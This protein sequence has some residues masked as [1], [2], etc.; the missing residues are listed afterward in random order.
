MH[1]TLIVASGRESDFGSLRTVTVE[2]MVIPLTEAF[3]ALR[4]QRPPI[5]LTIQQEIDEAA[6]ILREGLKS[7]SKPK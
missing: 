2:Q 4:K 1:T 5:G 6:K 7:P 3:E